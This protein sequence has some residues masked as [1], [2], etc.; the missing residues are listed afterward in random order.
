MDL[1]T[2]NFEI[3]NQIF[4]QGKK[5]SQ[6]DKLSVWERAEKKTDERH[7]IEKS[8]VDGGYFII[9][10]MKI[11]HWYRQEYRYLENKDRDRKPGRRVP[12]SRQ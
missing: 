2:R 4:G 5:Q 12:G 10:G 6:Y 3:I 8:L 1:G 9:E 11:E 7:A